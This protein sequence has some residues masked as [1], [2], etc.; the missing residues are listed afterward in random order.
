MFEIKNLFIKMLKMIRMKKI[1]SKI[2]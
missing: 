2:F 1:I